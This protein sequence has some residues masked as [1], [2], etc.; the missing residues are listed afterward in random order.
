MAPQH[1]RFGMVRSLYL[2][3]ALLGLCWGASCAEHPVL[4]AL[5]GAALFPAAF[6]KTALDLFRIL[7]HKPKT[8]PHETKAKQFPIQGRS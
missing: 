5:I 3:C 6:V 8:T 2:L 4:F 7:T 1:K